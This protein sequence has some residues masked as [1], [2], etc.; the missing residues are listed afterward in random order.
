MDDFKSAGERGRL[1]HFLLIS[2][3]ILL[4]LLARL[5][6]HTPNLSPFESLIMVTGCY[7]SR[8]CA[9]LMCLVALALSDVA[10]SFFMGYSVLGNW[11][12]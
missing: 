11:T 1:F 8:R 6:P 2:A 5:L 12:I 3:W 7:Y 10:L 4:A 9:L